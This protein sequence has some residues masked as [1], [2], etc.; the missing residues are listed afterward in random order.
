MVFIGTSRDPAGEHPTVIRR[1][2]VHSRAVYLNE[3]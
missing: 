1:N 3:I 2:I